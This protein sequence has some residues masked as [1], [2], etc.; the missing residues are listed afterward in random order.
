MLEELRTHNH[1][2]R[3]RMQRIAVDVRDYEILC[4]NTMPTLGIPYRSLPPELLDAIGHDPSAVTGG[5][6]R[7]RG[8]QAVEDIHDRIARQRQIIGQFLSLAGEDSFSAP[9]VLDKPIMSLMEKLE[10][11]E[12]SQYPL[13]EKA[14]EVGKILAEVKSVHGTVKQEYNE[15][16][17]QTSVVYPEVSK[18][19]L[20]YA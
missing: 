9:D 17:S 2:L 16:L 15:A 4:S 20:C 8:W 1:R 13:R 19:P 14:D 5:T 18:C 10:A 3:H 6:R 7:Y 12:K 11:L